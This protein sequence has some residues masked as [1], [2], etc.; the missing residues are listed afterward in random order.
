MVLLEHFRATTVTKI[1]LKKVNE[2]TTLFKSILK[3]KIANKFMFCPSPFP[4]QMV[5]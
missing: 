3:Y 2:I 1:R 4:N 5:I